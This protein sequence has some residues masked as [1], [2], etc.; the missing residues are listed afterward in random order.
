MLHISI[1][2]Q[3]HSLL[4][5]HIDR[6]TVD[7]YYCQDGLLLQEYE[8]AA[9]AWWWMQSSSQHQAYQAHGFTISSRQ[10]ANSSKVR[11]NVAL[12]EVISIRRPVT[13]RHQ[14]LC[15]SESR[16]SFRTTVPKRGQSTKAVDHGIDSKLLNFFL[17][18]QSFQSC[19]HPLSTHM[20][21]WF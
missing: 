9:Q 6:L 17:D 11:V 14:I 15:R 12:V 20:T 3:E 7:Y 16:T 18:H 4:R 5:D 13:N 2:F 8:E 10:I 1:C 21:N 19:L